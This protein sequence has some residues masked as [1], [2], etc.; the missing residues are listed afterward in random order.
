MP[1][2]DSLCGVCV[3]HASWYPLLELQAQPV[4]EANKNHR[5]AII[6]YVRKR[7]SKTDFKFGLGS[8]A[9]YIGYIRTQTRPAIEFVSG[10]EGVRPKSH[11]TVLSF[12]EYTLMHAL[13][14]V[15]APGSSCGAEEDG[16]TAPLAATG[17][18]LCH[19]LVSLL[20]V[21]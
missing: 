6:W 3:L 11:F 19:C 7:W 17:P 14:Y 16:G 1:W 4:V 9:R 15:I 21:T 13:E 5:G 10:E 12:V 20:P 2:V 18:S 8:E